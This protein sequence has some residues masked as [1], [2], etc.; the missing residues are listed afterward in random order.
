MKSVVLPVP[1]SSRAKTP[2]AL[3]A[4]PLVA[5]LTAAL[6]GF[7]SAQLAPL[8]IG[9]TDSATIALIEAEG[10]GYPR[11]SVMLPYPEYFLKGWI[12]NPDRFGP[13]PKEIGSSERRCVAV[14]P[15]GVMTHWDGRIWVP[16]AYMRSGDFMVSGGRAMIHGE[17]QKL[18]WTPAWPSRSMELLIRARRLSE[19]TEAPTK[20][21]AVTVTDVINTAANGEEPRPWE[22][23]FPT[24][25]VFPS[26][27]TWVVVGTSAR[28]WGCLV[29]TVG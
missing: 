23:S 25:I 9:E 18:P 1:L 7:A 24:R 19:P 6:S 29:Y 14:P 16:T 20:A 11:A 21:F 28:N 10:V 3:R 12:N 27:G 13:P 22:A 4:A 17:G 2:A 5:I 26:A 15:G 8:P